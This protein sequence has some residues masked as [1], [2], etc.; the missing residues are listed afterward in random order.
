M[1][2]RKIIVG[3]MA[4]LFAAASFADAKVRNVK[5]IGEEALR[6]GKIAAPPAGHDFT[7]VQ[8]GASYK[9][10]RLLVR[11]E[12]REIKGKLSGMS[13]GEKKRILDSLGG[14]KEKHSFDMVPGLSLVELPAGMTVE[15]ALKK[16]NKKGG[17]LYAEPDYKIT[18]GSTFPNDTS[19]ND[20]WGLHNIGQS[21]GTSDADIDAPEAWDIST[22][23]DI[24]V[25]VI[26]SGV[27]YTHPDLADN[28]WINTGEVPDNGIDDD[29][30]GYI[31]DIRG[32]NFDPNNNDPMDYEPHGT[33]CAGIVGAVGNNE[34]GITGVCWNVKIMALNIDTAPY[35]WEAFVSNACKAIDYA[36]DNGAQVLNASWG[37]QD[38]SQSLMDKICVAGEAG[39]LFVACAQNQANFSSLNNDIRPIY[40]ASYDLD[41]IIAVLAT[42][43]NDGIWSGSH[44]GAT[45]VDLGAPGSDILSCVPGGDYESWDGTSMATPYVAGACALIWSRNQSLNYLQVRDII[46]NTVDP[47]QALNGKCVTGGRLNLYKAITAVPALDLTKADNVT[48]GSSVL[49]GDDIIYT[50]SYRNPVTEPCLGIVSD[51]NIIDYLPVELEFISAS[52]SNSVYDP[53][54]HTVTWHIGTLLPGNDFNFITLT[55]KVNELAKPLGTIT[56]TC[57]VEASEIRLTSAV[58]ITNV[59]SWKPDIVYVNKHSPSWPKTGMSWENAYLELRDALNAFRISGCNEIW[60]AKE[61]YKPTSNPDDDEATF[62]LIDG[63]GLYGGFAGTETTRSQRNWLTNPTT[64]DGHIDDS[65]VLYLVTASN[66]SETTIVDGFTITRSTS[67]NVLIDGSSP[68]IR[69]NNITGGNTYGIHCKNQSS[70][71]ITDCNIQNN[72]SYGIY[73]LGSEPNVINSLIKDN[74]KTGIYCNQS[75]LAVNN[76]TIEG[77]KGCG[78]YNTAFSSAIVANSII[79]NNR[80][81]GSSSG[82]SHGI[83]YGPIS[84]QTTPAIKNNLIY[85]NSGNGIMIDDVDAQVTILNNTI[86]KNTSGGITHTSPHSISHEITNCIVWGNSS[87]QLYAYTPGP[88]DV[89]YSCIQG[90]SLYPGEHNIKDDPCFVDYANND[91]H[92]SINLDSPCIDIGNNSVAT[93]PYDIDQQPRVMG[94]QVD[95]GADEAFEEDITEPI[96]DNW[97]KFDDGSGTNADDSAG[98]ND[99]TLI[100]MEPA[101]DWVT[102]QIVGA[103]D[104]DGV[105]DYVDVPSFTVDT[106]NGTISLWFKTSADFSGNYGSQGYLISQDS[107]YVG[108]LTVEGNG[109]VPYKIVGETNTQDDYFVTADDAAPAGVWNHVVVS[110]YEKVAKTYLNGELIQTEPVT[111]SSLTLTR[112][113]GRTSEFFNGQIDDVRFYDKALNV[114]EIEQIYWV[115]RGLKAYCPNPGDGARGVDPNTE[116]SWSPNRYAIS[117]D[118]YFGTDYD[119]VNDADT[120]STTV[121]KGNYD[122]STFDPCEVG[123][124]AGVTYYWRI[125]EGYPEPVVKGDVWSF[126]ISGVEPNLVRLWELNG[127]ADDSANGYDGTVYGATWTTGQIGDALSF[128]GSDDYMTI[129]SYTVS[130]NKGTISFWFKTSADF[131]SNYGGQGFL[132][133]KDSQYVGYLTLEEEGTGYYGIVGETDSQDDY[134]VIAH[135]VA[136]ED[137]WN[138]IAVSFDNKQATTY[139][140]GAIIDDSRSVT[141][142]Y[143]TLTRI[144]GVSTVYFNGQIDDVRFYDK[145]LS[146]VEVGQIYQEDSSQGVF[147]LCYQGDENKKAS[148]PNPADEATGVGVN[149]DLSWTAGE[150]AQTHDVYFGDTNQPAFVCNQTGTTFNPGILSYGTTYYWRI[151]ESNGVDTTTGDI[152]SFTTVAGPNPNRWWKLDECN[153][154]TA[155][156]CVGD[157]DGTFNGDDPCWVTGKF[158]GAVDFDGVTDYFSVSSLNSLF[159]NSSVFTIAGWFNT[160]Q[161]TGMQTIVGQWSQ[162]SGDYY[163]WQVLVENNKVVAKFGGDVAPMTEITGTIN[164]SSGWHHFVLV[165][166]GS[167]NAILYVDGEPDGTAGSK[168]MDIYDTKFRIGDG[169]YGSGTLEGGPFNGMID[170]VMIFNRVLSAEEVKQLYDEGTEE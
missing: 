44:Y 113:G 93:W 5:A 19:F 66:V 94:G 41:N 61:T 46:L 97:W 51:V 69:H 95:I 112:I 133:S 162:H 24:I 141:N 73:S 59:N 101:T 156:D 147:S 118:V 83:Y 80:T 7:K 154:V 136:P 164:V 90:S 151:D 142:S 31:D 106:N 110:F 102:G 23:S 14:A 87:A 92:L 131:S 111:D 81:S 1:L 170:N 28:I 100:N 127:N 163:G 60:V 78:V 91:Y 166:N 132:I 160:D 117:H 43:H 114:E 50:I 67:A 45:S 77:N 18:F 53:L 145:A 119:D 22:H 75:D 36:V 104:F 123:L 121:Y 109:T 21:G 63:A 140:N 108:Y 35:T 2:T 98:N 124:N 55:V 157:D 158:N 58:E 161:S 16:F 74:Q 169:S 30:N 146:E 40:P 10:G 29:D 64:L 153:G 134:F 15:E 27:D 9:E 165:N 130:T 99:G 68:I 152:W 32:W 155:Y 33:H 47:I 12:P 168:Y 11:F 17:I 54:T 126:K 82:D 62:E 38:Y 4:V 159:N 149:S 48:D 138:H 76:C 135:D 25:A 26:D 13:V 56:N 39:V 129:P 96:P 84:Q 139:L 148:N 116:L 52:G 105:D 71:T 85:N 79:R 107:K 115:G 6:N 167:S 88:F 128:D 49:P 57:V 120:S 65:N 70:P 144:G 34:E 37:T 20:L 103:L 72:R 86:T 137:N 150:E 42:N 125:D 3:I 122:I 8:P 143:L 89:T